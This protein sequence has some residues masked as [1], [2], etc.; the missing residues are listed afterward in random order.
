MKKLEPLIWVDLLPKL[1]QKLIELLKSLSDQD[2]QKQSIAPLWKVKDIAC[3]AFARWKHPY[4][5]YPPR[6][7]CRRPSAKH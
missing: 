3:R 6:R 2:W 5:F 7:L 4:A 1:D